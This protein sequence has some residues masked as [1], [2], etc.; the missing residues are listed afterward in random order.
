MSL[1]SGTSL[2][3][4]EIV[5]PLGAGGMGEVYRARDSR[6]GRD[7]ALKVIL[8]EATANPDRVARFEKEARA[9][10]ALNHP[11]IV[12]V[13]DIGNSATGPFIVSEL[14]EGETLGER[15]ARGRVP[16]RLALEIGAQVARGLAAAHDKGIVHRDL[17]PDNIFLTRNGGAKIL[18]FGLAKLRENVPSDAVDATVE[19]MAERHSTQP[20][21]VMGTVGY[22]APEQVR[23]E[24]ADSR[25][26]VFALGCVLF[27][28]IG[29]QR[30][31][32]GT[33][34]IETLHAI[35]TAEP[36]DVFGS[37]PTPIAPGVE[38]IVRR[39]LE[40]DPQQRFQSVRDLAFALEAVV[41]ARPTETIH[42]KSVSAAPRRS[43][44]GLVPW[45]IAALLAVALAYAMWPQPAA[46]PMPR[47]QFDIAAGFGPGSN[48]IAISPQGTHIAS[49]VA[50]SGGLLAVQT[51]ATQT[52]QTLRGTE[53][54]AWPFWSPDGQ[55]VGFF[56]NGKLKRADLLGG[57]PQS[58]ADVAM[59]AGGSW[60]RD[61]IILFSPH[62]NGPLQRVSA[63]GGAATPVTTLSVERGDLGHRHPWFLPDGRHFIYTLVTKDPKQ[64][65]IYVGDLSGGAAK[66]LT[67]TPM[68]AAFAPPNRLLFMRDNVLLQQ[69]LDLDRLELTGDPLPVSEEVAAFLPNSAAGFS[70]ADNGILAYRVNPAMVQSD[71]SLQWYSRDGRVSP[72]VEQ[73]AVYQDP[74][75]SPDGRF[76]VVGK[77]V[78]GGPNGK[79]GSDLWVID[80]A[81]GAHSKFSFDLAEERFGRWSP[82]GSSITFDRLS[83]ASG[84]QI[85]RRDTSGVRPEQLLFKGDAVDRRASDWSPDGRYVLYTE[86]DPKTVYDLWVTP[87]DGSGKPEPVVRSQFNDTNGRFSPDGKWLAYSTNETGRPEVYVI[88]FPTTRN[89]VQIS[90]TGG[91]IPRWR[92]DSKELFF[93]SETGQMMATLVSESR[94]EL[95][96]G[97][98]RKLFDA[99]PIGE[100]DVTRDGQRF[101]LN[102]STRPANTT[103]TGAPIRVIVNWTTSPN[104]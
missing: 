91:V 62:V 30:A 90:T 101:L 95:R 5:E 19:T 86:R 97:V 36:P 92:G 37:A 76:V 72:A 51:L 78:G 12:A 42:I 70:V 47:I 14:L 41:D 103:P 17:K 20:G 27:E 53:Q 10:A 61:G 46:A 31:F 84:G 24:P 81:R 43:V 98:P 1:K 28:L 58:I 60:N 13:F 34:Q 4:Y 15:L 63:A 56:A 93:M 89:R 88:G 11:N 82:D 2:G 22:M 79:P 18:D 74:S 52:T 57:P 102:V 50:E 7:V 49:I 54:P 35:L 26:D 6:L 33:S 21:L 40:K 8:A 59:G 3:P 87:A 68:K 39:C 69:T 64:T 83:E 66:F 16:V 96:A 65:G 80:L 71:T 67:E 100:W 29:G 73:T 25:A 45:G 55:H 38:R 75:L 104:Q 9:T 23:G 99:Q 85:Y 32:T 94:G 48:Q 44:A 77:Y